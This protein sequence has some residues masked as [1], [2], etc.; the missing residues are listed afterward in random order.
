MR[1]TGDYATIGGREYRVVARG[2]DCAQREYVG[3]LLDHAADATAFSE[4]VERGSGDRMAKVGQSELE[5]LE[6]VTT[7]GTVDGEE[8]ILYGLGDLIPCSFVGDPAWADAHGLTGSQH[9]GWSGTVR[10]ADITGLRETVD[11]L[12]H[13]ASAGGV[14]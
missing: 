12:L 3:L 14:R 5:R 1:P 9:D 10:R 6:R 11:D 7:T 13:P 2:S 4:I 8:L